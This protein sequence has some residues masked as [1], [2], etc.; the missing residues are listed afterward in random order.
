MFQ[1]FGFFGR[2][3]SEPGFSGLQ[4]FQDK[5]RGDWGGYMCI[6]VF[7]L[8][9]DFQDYRIFR[10]FCCLNQDFQDYRI[11]RIRE[12]GIGEGIR[13]GM[14]TGGLSEPGF[15]GLQDYQDWEMVRIDTVVKDER[16]LWQRDIGISTSYPANPIILKI[17]VQTEERAG[18][19]RPYGMFRRN[20]DISLNTKH[21]PC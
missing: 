2:F 13:V 4:D 18:K 1:I 8:N 3:L 12:E 6:Q 21:T 16:L 11:S 9:Q 19:P 10:I 17:L 7:F 14:Y 20:M 5:R 15:T